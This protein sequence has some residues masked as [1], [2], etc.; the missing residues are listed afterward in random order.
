MLE[1]FFIKKRKEQAFW[2]WFLK[3]IELYFHFMGKKKP[4][5]GELRPVNYNYNIDF[6]LN[7]H[8]VRLAPAQ[9]T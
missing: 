1:R 5:S 9:I 2:D 4:Q 6:G 7:Q 3:N 8:H